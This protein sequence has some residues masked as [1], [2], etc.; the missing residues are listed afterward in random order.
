MKKIQSFDFGAFNPFKMTNAS[1]EVNKATKEG[2]ILFTEDFFNEEDRREWEVRYDN[3]Y[4]NVFYDPNIN[5]YR[6]YYSTFTK[7]E[8]SSNYSLEERKNRTYIPKASRIV[9][10]CYAESEDGVNWEKPNLGITEWKGSKNNNII[11]HFLHGSS[12]LLDI[13][14]ENPKK[15]YK[16]FTKIDYGN[17]VHFIGVSFSE[18]GIT[19][20]DFIEIPGFNPRADTHNSV[21]FDEQLNKYV[22]ITRSWRDSLRIPV[23]STSSD[24]INWSSVKEIL[25][26][27]GY[28]NQVYSMPMFIDGD[29][30]IGLPSMFHEGDRD[31][32]NFDLVDVELA[33]SYQYN[34][35]NYIAPNTPFIERGEGNYQSGE[36]DNGCIY[37]SLP[38]RDGIRTYFYYM[39]G[40][41]QHTNFRE[42]SLS[43]AYIEHDRYTY[44]QQKDKE[45]EAI[46]Y[47]NGF[48]L[49]SNEFFLDADI[50]DNGFVE[51]EL[52]TQGHEK[53]SDV[54]IT[55]EK[56]DHRYKV[57]IDKDLERMRTHLKITFKDARIYNFEGDF[58][59]FRV[60]SDTSLLR[61]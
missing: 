43:R 3:S 36:F 57:I 6:A 50:G 44:Y 14:E 49:L 52:Y 5:K 59:V 2:K 45:K 10:L 27:R 42:T 35:W 38:V 11:G 23:I 34:G 1:L 16:M 26:P 32:E 28:E 39:G 13:H 53:I 8:E 7:D 54:N 41:G 19:F 55:L 4:P 22:L 17:G 15:K 61:S 40:N 31:A 29:Y 56:V 18:D 25:P 58:D 51:I 20:D 46:L 24:F 33:Y 48:I 47:T 12:V 30:R 60:E 37:A 9:S 21:I